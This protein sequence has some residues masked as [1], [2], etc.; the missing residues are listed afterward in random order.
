MAVTVGREH[1]CAAT[2]DGEFYCW[3]TN[4]HGQIGNPDAMIQEFPIVVAPRN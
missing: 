1:S 4:Y 2:R 3:G